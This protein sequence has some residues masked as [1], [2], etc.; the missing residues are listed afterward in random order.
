MPA[1]AFF[2]CLNYTA[3]TRYQYIVMRCLYCKSTITTV[4]NSRSTHDGDKIWRRRTCLEC[5]ETFTTSEL[6]DTSHIIVVKNAGFEEPFS[7]LKLN[8]DIFSATQQFRMMGRDQFVDSISR[9]IVREILA[10]KKNKIESSKI[11]ESVLRLLYRRHI[12]TFLAYLIEYERI[13]SESVLQKEL[14]H[15][16]KNDNYS[17]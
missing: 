12:P 15:F 17:R 4:K 8:S 1:L 16:S 11:A 10:L 5:N 14:A 3:A 2:P 9:E 13:T 7:R 6:A